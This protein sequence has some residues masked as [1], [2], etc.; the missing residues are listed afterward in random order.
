MWWK[1]NKL[2]ACAY[3]IYS[4]VLV[5]KGTKF[6]RSGYTVV[7]SDAPA[8]PIRSDDLVYKDQVQAWWTSSSSSEAHPINL[9][10]A[11]I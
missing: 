8:Q 4:P 7:I 1:W 2:K 5:G 11:G 6:Q 10:L 3:N 9:G